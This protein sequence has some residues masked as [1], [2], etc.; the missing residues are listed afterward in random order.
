M[1]EERW[2][3][4]ISILSQ[5]HYTTAE[6][7]A[8]ILGVS[9]KTV[10][11]EIKQ[12]ESA[13]EKHG[14]NIE[15]KHGYGYRLLVKNEDK[16]RSFLIPQ[17]EGFIDT[18]EK[19][20]QYLLEYFLQTD[21]FIKTDDL[22]DML[23]V[24]KKTLTSDIKEVERILSQ[25]DIAIERK[26]YYGMRIVRDEFKIRL[27]MAQCIQRKTERVG[28]GFDPDQNETIRKLIMILS[29]CFDKNGFLITD[30]ALKSLA[31]HLDI[32]IRRV[33][34]QN[35]VFMDVEDYK[36]WLPEREVLL[37]R[38][39]AE[40][41]AKAFDVVF[42]EE[43]IY[44]IAVHL[45]G[46]KADE[47]GE[48]NLIIST[49]I[50]EL[51]ME[52][53]EEIYRVFRVDFRKDLE[54]VMSLGKHMEPLLIRLQFGM[55]M[56]NPVLKEI[57]EKFCMAYLMSSFA[58]SV[59]TRHYHKAL[60]PDEIGYI[61]LA[62]MLALER[63][64][65]QSEKKNIVLVCASGYGTAK[66]MEY[67][68][69]ELFGDCI[70]QMTTCDVRHVGK[71]DFTN[72]DYV[73]T[74][75]P[76]EASI[77]VPICDVQFFIKDEEVMQVRKLLK[78]DTSQNTIARFY[79]Q[80][81]FFTDLVSTTK[82]AVLAEICGR[83]QTVYELPNGFLESVLERESLA[84]TVF[85]LPAAM[86]HTCEA[87]T[88]DTFVSVSVLDKPVEWIPGT[89][90]RVIFLISVAASGEKPPREFYSVTSSVLLNKQAIQELIREKNYETLLKILWKAEELTDV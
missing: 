39:C 38:E 65:K 33:Q 61:A 70:A 73:F 77:P 41:I 31:V 20:V 18:S 11:N 46:K 28:F 25:Y 48:E 35:Y 80:E 76:I 45:A 24:C 32:A 42:P 14:A 56:K 6:Q 13:L 34:E 86:P 44:Y 78:R 36:K 85:G 15:S 72:V 90:V 47:N 79:P 8:Q 9:T 37:A 29:D 12:L 63:R 75:V 68:M 40:Q 51:V 49:E 64:Q 5:E 57:K 30:V 27:C 43:E 54:L 17:E 22:C 21:E 10:R 52:M 4:I 69:Q 58:C 53:L 82:E 23:C 89:M 87:M 50:N 62:F 26:P 60:S 81:M 84:Q 83:I 3:K 74:S 7:I 67:K 59:I 66:L 16:L 71:L 88:K 1:I 19:R 55:R 2:S